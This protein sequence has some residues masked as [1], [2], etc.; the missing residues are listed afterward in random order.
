[1]K[2]KH[3]DY[4]MMILVVFLILF[5]LGS[6][7][8]VQSLNRVS[9]NKTKKEENSIT[10]LKKKEDN[11]EAINEEADDENRQINEVKVTDIVPIPKSGIQSEQDVIEYVENMESS[12]VNSVE[13]DTVDWKIKAKKLFITVIDFIFYDGK[14]GNYTFQQLSDTGKQKVLQITTN[15]D[16]IIESYSPNY[17]ERLVSQGKRTYQTVSEKLTEYKNQYFADVKSVIGEDNY[18][19]AGTV[20]DEVKEKAS[21]V[22]DK[23]V[24]K[25]KDI[26][27]Q[28]KETAGKLKDKWND[29][30]QSWKQE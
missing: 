25:S 7:I 15:I 28:G 3:N 23:V 6:F 5:F 4:I 18:E 11:Q 9:S 29:W 13:K 19:Q 24:D 8:Y 30:Y 20:Y 1:M 27:Q 26:Y 22:K 10:E 2:E 21:S 16:G 14:I 17:K 12:I